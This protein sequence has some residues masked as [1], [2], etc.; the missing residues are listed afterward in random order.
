MR[1]HGQLD[2]VMT[3]RRSVY[4]WAHAAATVAPDADVHHGHDVTGLVAAVAA[5]NG[6]PALVVYDSHELYP[7]SGRHA[8]QGP[9]ARCWLRS[10]ERRLARHAVALVTVNR[11]LEA[12]LRKNLG[13][14]RSVVVHNAPPRWTPPDPAPD[15]LRERLHLPPEARIALYH[16]GFAPD[17]G[18]AQLADAVLEPGMDDTHL[19]FLGY[20]RLRDELAERAADPAIRRAHPPA[21]RRPARRACRLG[22]LGRRRRHAQPAGQR[23][24]A[25]VHAQQA[26]RVDGRRTTGRLV[27]LPGTSPDHP[28]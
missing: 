26:L 16:G 3:W 19:V 13:F 25:A 28:R 8:R 22:R 1:R 6:T 24:P 12:I 14:T 10:L 15:L 9:F 21:R 18:L 7:E 5:A 27:G 23:K 2:Y 17:R 11:T 20:G 4:G